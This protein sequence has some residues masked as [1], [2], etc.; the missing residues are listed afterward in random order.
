M[1][2]LHVLPSINPVTGGP[3]KSVL[4]QL[5]GLARLGHY[6]ELFTTN[7]P[8]IDG[9]AV[10]QVL[11]QDGVIVRVFPA[12]Q[13]WP[14]TQVPYSR[15]LIASVREARGRFDIYIASSLWNPLITH[16][17]ALYRRYGLPYSIYCH[18]MLDPVVFARH[19]VG[20]WVWAQLWERRNVEEAEL[21]YF[22]TAGERQK[23]QAQGWR[24]R[25][26][27]VMAID[28]DVSVGLTL[29]PR[30]RLER[31]Y[32][33]LA[34]KDV[35]AFVGRI[36]WVKNL[37]LLVSA[38]EQVRRLGRDAVLLCVGPDSDG[39]R[40][41]LE[42]QALELGIADKVAFTG[43]LMGEDLMAVYARADV[44]ALV[45]RKENFGLA[46]AEA[47][48]AGVPVVLSD[49]VDMG[50]DWVAPPVWRVRQNV[51]SIAEGLIGALIYAQETGAPSATARQLAQREWGA[52]QIQSLADAYEAI[53]DIRRS[54]SVANGSR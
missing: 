11:E 35:V 48:A 49:G 27:F 18:G 19:R 47:L 34:G 23:A 31:D 17:L 42:R 51:G 14:L 36:N 41:V 53:V 16:T 4:L 43:L 30:T 3:A 1:R 40:K 13:L 15:G 46:A 20:K 45:S 37:D 26:P 12:T 44:V 2:I 25:R 38:L 39:S 33:W 7:W 9:D 21:I 32:P 28:V 10:E 8:E 22:T 29:P 6:V 50:P 5:K 52:S 24:L 54:M